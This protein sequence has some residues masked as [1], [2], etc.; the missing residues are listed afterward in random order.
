[1]KSSSGQHFV[2]LDHVRAC[3][4]FLVVFW[5][6]AHASSGTPVPFGQQPVLGL[7]DE[8]HT[9]VAL[10]MTLSGYLFAKLLD[11]KSINFGAFLWNRVIRLFPL[12]LLVI[13]LFGARE[14][15]I[16]GQDPLAYLYRMIWGFVRPT[17]PNGGWSITVEIHFYL[18]LPLL[19]YC[20]RKSNL[21][22]LAAVVAMLAARSILY[23]NGE[24]VH[25][26]AYWTIVGRIDQFL[27]GIFL[28]RIKRPVPAL[29]AIA[30]LLTL[31]GFYAWFDAHGGWYNLPERAKAVWIIIPTIEGACYASIIAWYDRVGGRFDNPFTRF[32][33]KAGE[34]SYSIYLL[35]FF[36]VFKAAAF[37]NARIMTIDTVITALPW[38][39]LFFAAM[40]VVGHFSYKYWEA[41][42]LRLRVKYLREPAPVAAPAT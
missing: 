38:A 16:S 2:A 39:M 31:G 27:W 25:W 7:L 11:D 23:L 32:L 26:F 42:F 34:Y 15:L 30:A 4:A 33:Q 10:F 24:D 21:T 13:G 20:A 6:F 12:L 35:H 3:A 8:G 29:W 19:L 40:V 1:M 5:H 17:W 37:I 14:I 41:P 28:Y 18:I 9:G 22:L 36:V